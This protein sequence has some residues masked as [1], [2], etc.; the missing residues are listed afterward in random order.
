[1][2]TGRYE[3]LALSDNTTYVF[4]YFQTGGNPYNALYPSWYMDIRT[5]NKIPL[6]NA[7]MYMI[8]SNRQSSK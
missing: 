4:T 7:S 3:L 8:N 2:S 6:K 1:M 5:D